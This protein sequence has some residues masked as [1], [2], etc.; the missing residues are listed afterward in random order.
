[1]INASNFIHH[2]FLIWTIIASFEQLIILLKL[3][4][5]NVLNRFLIPFE[6][7]FL[8]VIYRVSAHIHKML[9]Q[10]NQYIMLLT[11]LPH[12]DRRNSIKWNIFSCFYLEESGHGFVFLPHWKRGSSHSR[13][14]NETIKKLFITA[15]FVQISL[16]CRIFWSAV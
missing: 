10:S 9:I 8:F 1:M 2:E 7:T 4:Y 16:F 12:R 13:H 15:M 3:N 5:F 6:G 11:C 14:P